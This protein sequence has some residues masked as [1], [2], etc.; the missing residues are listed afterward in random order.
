MPVKTNGYTHRVLDMKK[1]M[2]REDAELRNDQYNKL[3]LHQK[4]ELVEGRGGSAKE[5][6]RLKAKLAEAN[7]PVAQSAKTVKKNS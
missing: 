4:I 3:S 6:A 2:R 5:L 1:D 7:V